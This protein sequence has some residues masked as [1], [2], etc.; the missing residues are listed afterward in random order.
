M[1]PVP[2]GS[3]RETHVRGDDL[4]VPGK[5][6]ILVPEQGPPHGAVGAVAPDDVVRLD[7]VPPARRLDVDPGPAGVLAD[8]DH[9][10]QP[11]DLAA[12]PPDEEV[13]HEPVEVLQRVADGAQVAPAD[14]GE[15]RAVE[16]GDAAV[17]P[18][19]APAHGAQ[20]EAPRPQLVEDARAGEVGRR[21]RAVVRRAGLLVQPVGHLDDDDGDAVLGEEQGQ[22]Q[23]GRAGA[24]Y[25]DSLERA[26]GHVH[27]SPAVRSPVGCVCV[28]T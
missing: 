17:V 3:T 20:A 27:C 10:V 5:P 18:E 22:Q 4:G 21:R 24:H 13:Q 16:P 2:P 6:G 11:P 15:H 1:R 25:E 12:V 14:V 23:A 26:F 28:C 7:P 9:P 8:A 19:A